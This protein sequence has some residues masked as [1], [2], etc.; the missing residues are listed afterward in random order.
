MKRR[1]K[2]VT[3]ITKQPILNFS[4]FIK[5][6]RFITWLPCHRDSL[7]VLKHHDK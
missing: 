2:S 3:E 1:R 4:H 7:I 6:C 5:H